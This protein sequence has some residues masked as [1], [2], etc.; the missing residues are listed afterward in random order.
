MKPFIPVVRALIRGENGVLMLRRSR[1]SG[2]NPSLWELPGGK[3]RAGETLD[4]ALSRE[5]HEET[6][7]MVRPLHLLGAYEQMFPQKVSVNIIFSVEVKGGALELSM[8]H[9]DFCW[10]RSGDLEFSPWLSEF[11]GD[12]PDLFRC[13]KLE[14]SEI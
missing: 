14:L 4:E 3:V 10:F 13:E 9:E 5:V 8:E 6:G 11:K 7:L 12:R 1:E 2:T